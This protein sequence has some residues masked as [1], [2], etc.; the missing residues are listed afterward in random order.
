M[1]VLSNYIREKPNWWEK[2][3]DKV[4][5]EKWREEALQREEVGGLLT[6]RKLTRKM[7]NSCNLRTTPCSHHDI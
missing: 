7:V 6:S 1:C 5:V 2:L 4:I 3:K